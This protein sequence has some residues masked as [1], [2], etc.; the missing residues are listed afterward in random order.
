MIARTCRIAA[1]GVLL[2]IIHD[3]QSR[4]TSLRGNQ[5]QLASSATAVQGTM[6]FSDMEGFSDISEDMRTFEQQFEGYGP[7]FIERPPDVAN[8]TKYDAEDARIIG[9]QSAGSSNSMVPNNQ[10]MILRQTGTTSTGEPT[11]A[12][13]NCGGTLITNCHVL[14]AAHCVGRYGANDAVLVNARNPYDT[15]NGGAPKWKSTIK[16]EEAHTQYN[17]G[18]KPYD[19]GIFELD[20][21]VPSNLLSSLP[22]ARVA[23]SLPGA[24]TD[25]VVAGFGRTDPNLSAKP[26][27]MQAVQVDMLSNSQC[28]QAYGSVI[29]ST[30]FCAGDWNGG[31]DS[32]QGDSGGGMYKGTSTAIQELI[33]VVSW[34]QGC[35]VAGKPGVYASVPNFFSWIKGKVCSDPGVI[36]GSC[37]LCG[38]SYQGV[39]SNSD[40]GTTFGTP[41]IDC[42]YSSSKTVVFTNPNNGQQVSTFCKFMIPAWPAVGGVQYNQYCSVPSVASTCAFACHSSCPLA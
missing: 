11:Y 29:D 18:S 8:T 6:N 30:Q 25:V 23:T 22:P 14:T 40:T 38:G 15:N 34:G 20:N 33:G 21:C 4:Q 32:C 3:T 24:G 17:S 27:T 28:T 36:A 12:P 5:R 31:K 37:P 1:I 39:Q 16:S 7:I 41:N 10:V 26:Q 35:A 19:V 13:N 9:G 42:T 2:M